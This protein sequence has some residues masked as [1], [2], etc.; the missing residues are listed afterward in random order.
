[1]KRLDTRISLLL[2]FV[3]LVACKSEAPLSRVKLDSGEYITKDSA[4]TADGTFFT[5]THVVG[6]SI[7]GACTGTAVSTTTVITAGHCVL[8]VA[9]R[10]GA[11]TEAFDQKT[12]AISGKEFCVS[13]KLYNR[14][15]STK[16]FVNPSYPD[17][18][19]SPGTA[20][21]AFVVFPEGTF[22]SFHYISTADL[23]VGD[24]VLMVGYSDKDLPEDQQHGAVKR[25]GFNTVAEFQ[26]EAQDDIFTD[27]TNSFQG[28]GLSPGDS[29]GPMMKDCKVTGL[30]SRS[31][32]NRNPKY[33]IHT[34]LTYNT[35]VD[36][37]KRFTGNG[38]YFCGVS[39]TD[40]KYCPA[41]FLNT[42]NPKAG[43]KE[44]PC[45]INGSPTNPNTPTPNTPTS[46]GLFAGLT[47]A[48][49][50]QVRGV[51]TLSAVDICVGI[52]L[53]AAKSC[54]DK[55][56]TTAS[57][58]DFKSGNLKIDGGVLWYLQ[59]NG[60]ETNGGKAVN[61]LIKLDRK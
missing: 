22:K 5:H 26:R 24:K 53:D 9:D 39:G 25:F 15:C 56:P 57:G 29:G 8:H 18:A 43:D 55:R 44:F 16:L 28:V 48:N 35:Q 50:L 49:E 23:R 38:A 11:P 10:Q 2:V 12:G 54:V 13:N 37:M 51:N 40:P 61:Q 7:G 46:S 6:S 1:M 36:F 59:I 58:Q 4:N 3:G 34:N 52:T 31:A 27:Y 20:D 19:H 33:G 17:A 32:L 41:E 21:S 14:V 42:V 47:E 60:T 30:A 45:A